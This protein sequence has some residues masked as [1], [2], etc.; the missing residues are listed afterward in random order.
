[1]K[2]QSVD[3]GGTFTYE[4]SYREA[5]IL[6]QATD[7][8]TAL[9][10]TLANE[11]TAKFRDQG[12]TEADLDAAFRKIHSDMHEVVSRF[13]QAEK[14]IQGTLGTVERRTFDRLVEQA[15]KVRALEEENQQLKEQ[16][17]LLTKKTAE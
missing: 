1:M 4:I 12:I 16:I 7:G 2:I 3:F 17:E 9:A 8:Y 15:D 11:V 6:Y 5:F 14:V 13:R 10:R